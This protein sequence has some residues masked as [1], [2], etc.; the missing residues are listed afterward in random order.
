[1]KHLVCQVDLAY[2]NTWSGVCSF[3]SV[4]GL[5]CNETNTTISSNSPVLIVKKRV[6]LWLPMHLRIQFEHYD[7]FGLLQDCYFEISLGYL[8]QNC[9]YEVYLYLHELTGSTLDLSAGELAR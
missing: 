6:L 5:N 9:V 7:V 8:V 1:M 4:F 2:S 3:T